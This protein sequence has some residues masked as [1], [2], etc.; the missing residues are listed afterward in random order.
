M[1][2]GER[3]RERKEKEEEMEMEERKRG[4]EMRK[5]RDELGEEREGVRRRERFQCLIIFNV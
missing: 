2:K 5:R 1:E 4:K 3:Y